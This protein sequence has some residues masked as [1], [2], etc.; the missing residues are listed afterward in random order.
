MVAEKLRAV[1]VS[2]DKDEYFEPSK[3]PLEVWCNSWL[4]EYTGDLKY[5]TRKTYAAQIRNHIIPSLG[6][7]QLGDLAKPDE[8]T[9]IT[10]V[11]KFIN[12]LTRKKNLSP[13]SVKNVHG[14]LSAVL[15]TAVTVGHIR[16]NPCHKIKLPRIPKNEV[17][18]LT[19]EQVKAFLNIVDG[20]AYYSP[21]FKVILFCGLRESEA[22]G[23]TWSSVD[24]KSGTIT[25]SKQ[26]QK[27]PK[28]DGGFVFDSTKSDKTRILKPAPFVME[29]L[30]Q[31][32]IQQLSA[33]LKASDQWQGW[34]SEKE[35]RGSVVFT[36]QFGVHLNPTTVYTHFKAL[37][38]QIGADSACVHD[39]RHTYATLSLQNGDDIKTLQENLGHA[40]A[41]FTL[42]RYG[43]VSEKMKEDSASRMEK[44]ID[45]INSKQA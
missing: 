30:H 18:P 19:E 5:L 44:F 33:K 4:E 21:L 38:A 23:L 42:D 2:V 43:H 20:D 3:I 39:L 10:P 8:R 31:Q 11:Q 6:A 9:G 1:T 35:R 32:S 36:N 40:T 12:D 29:V 37:A 22:I 24:F 7:T 27:R 41:A 17:R 15:D 16:A 45:G 14:V 34:S 25:I 26:L 13:K 28:K